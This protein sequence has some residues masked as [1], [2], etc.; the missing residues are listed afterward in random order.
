MRQVGDRRRAEFGQ[1]LVEQRRRRHAVDIEVA[2]HGDRLARAAGL[3][4]PLDG[5][6]DV[7]QHR[8]RGRCRI[9]EPGRLSCGFDASEG[10]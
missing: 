10:Q 8:L 2:K 5:L 9:E 3:R 7:W 1:V 6:V 4:E